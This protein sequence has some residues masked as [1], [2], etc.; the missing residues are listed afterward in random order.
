MGEALSQQVQNPVALFAQDNNG[1][2][3]E[4]PA[5][6]TPQASVTGSLIFGIGTQSNNGVGS[7]TIYNVDAFG[8]FITTYKNVAYDQS[9]ID[10]GSNGFFFLT[11]SSTG[12]PACPDADFFYC[13][14]SI[15]NLSAVTAGATG[16]NSNTINFSVDNADNLFNNNPAAFVFPTLAGP[17][18]L[19]G[20]DWGLPFFFGR[21]VFTAI[22]GKSTPSGSGPYWAY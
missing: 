20:F 16:S 19:S 2:I 15:Q 11:S 12:I 22:E 1:V 4:L 5:V 6:T 10:S 21:N 18:S 17:N 8:N 13:P 9:F 7:A 14:T 3:I